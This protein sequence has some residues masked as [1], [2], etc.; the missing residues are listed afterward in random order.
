MRT[1]KTIIIL[2]AIT[3]FLFLTAGVLSFAQTEKAKPAPPPAPTY[4]P[5]KLT[6]YTS[7]FGRSSYIQGFA[8]AEALNKHSTW[9]RGTAEETMGS[10]DNVKLGESS[11]EAKKNS[12][13]VVSE[14]PYKM[15]RDGKKPF[16]TTHRDLKI[17]CV[18][19]RAAH[20]FGTLDSK[21]KT[22]Q[23]MIGKKVAVGPKT[24]PHGIKGTDQLK[25]CYEILDKVKLIN[26]PAPDIGE[27]LIDGI[28]DVGLLTANPGFPKW[29]K[30]ETLESLSAQHKVYPIQFTL[31]QL[32][33]SVGKAETVFN[34]IDIPV[35][36]L[37]PGQT[38]TL[39]SV[40]FIYWTAY[41]DLP[42]EVVY[43]VLRMFHDF[44]PDFVEQHQLMKAIIPGQ[45]GVGDFKQEEVHPGALKF[46]KDRGMKVGL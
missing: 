29:S 22:A 35:D 18:G 45:L 17:V 2:I 34:P 38:S 20:F 4:K 21:I 36:F 1:H 15:A 25:Y 12:L 41:A 9:L 19:F 43:E 37:F 14:T 7:Q 26:M 6:M 24:D 32:K 30:D 44:Q 11:P 46:Y 27:A 28:A 33:K 13:M 16:D 10:S 39:A 40:S 5:F 3:F 8:L 31:E 42:N 23:D